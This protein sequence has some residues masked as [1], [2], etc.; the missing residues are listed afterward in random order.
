VAKPLKI[1][2]PEQFDVVYQTLPDVETQLLVET[3][4][5]S[6]LRW[7]E[8]TEL[9]VK[10][11][12]FETRILTVSR[13]VVQVGPEFHPTGKRFCVKKYP[14]GKKHRRLKLSDQIV[15][16]LKA[17]RDAHGLSRDD[18]FSCFYS[19]D[20]ID[21]LGRHRMSLLNSTVYPR[22]FPAEVG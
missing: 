2:T 19:K 15:C 1:I 9:R 13:A 17:H 16:K 18:S 5:E 21:E 7:G 22:R 6:G 10:D 12:D 20:S 8:L 11:L 14:K 3:D 4:I